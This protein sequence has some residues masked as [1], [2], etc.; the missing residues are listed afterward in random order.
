MIHKVLSYFPEKYVI[1]LTSQ[2]YMVWSTSA[3]QRLNSHILAIEEAPELNE[4]Q[5]YVRQIFSKRRLKLLPLSLLVEEMLKPKHGIPIIADGE[6]KCGE[7]IAKALALGA[8]TAI[9]RNLFA[10]CNETPTK[11]I[12]GL[13]YGL[14]GNINYITK[15]D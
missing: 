8:D 15:W 3:K 14:E 9:C 7:D 11:I 12:N 4:A 5:P 1:W 13:K 6:I 10:G 2:Q